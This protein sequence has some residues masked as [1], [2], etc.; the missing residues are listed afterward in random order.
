MPAE[1]EAMAYN[2]ERGVPWHGLGVP[3]EGLMTAEE[4]I[5]KAG[6]DWTVSP[7]PISDEF[8]V[9][10]DKVANRRST[11]HA[12][13]G[14]VGKGFERV[15]NRDAFTFANAL[16]AEN[17]GKALYDTAGSL[18]TGRTVF[19]SMD[20]TA[21]APINIA[22]EKFQTFLLLSNSHDGSKALR[23]SITPVRVVCMNTLNA[24][25]AGASATF[26]IRHSGNIDAKMQAAREAL[27]L[28]IDYIA[29]FEE[30]AAEAIKVKVTDD[31]AEKVLRRVFRMS[32]KTAER[33]EGK[34]FEDH[35]AVR[36][37]DIYQTADDLAPFRGTAWGV[38]N[39]VAE[40][41]DHDRQYGAAKS[42]AERAADLRMTALL[43]GNGQQ[44][45][46]NTLGLLVPKAIHPKALARANALPV[47]K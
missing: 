47:A 10:P 6:L 19:L 28:T 42:K 11:D 12:Y 45:V 44:A 16:V 34:T 41:V 23:A 46:T 33:G 27:G 36:A 1:V 2:I 3:V 7:Y 31:K 29:R 9:I 8:G 30:V 26:A 25:I 40:Y 21:V 37:L 38:V 32:E 14:T 24:A 15:Q 4:A 20:L 5:E 39:A 17:E 22:D 43:W 13:L 18:T 35:A